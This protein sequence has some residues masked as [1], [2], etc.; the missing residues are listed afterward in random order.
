M[1]RRDG[2]MRPMERMEK[3]E[4]GGGSSS[5]TGE[6]G[7]RGGGRAEGRGGRWEKRTGGT[8]RGENEVGEED[9]RERKGWTAEG[10]EWLRGTEGNG[11]IEFTLGR[12]DRD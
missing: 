6:M 11:G 9:G 8:Q 4:L 10:V 3:V 7:W 12:K 1:D 5:D 2:G